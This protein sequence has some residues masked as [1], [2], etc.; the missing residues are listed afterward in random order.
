MSCGSG[1]SHGGR[2]RG[3]VAVVIGQRVTAQSMRGIGGQGVSAF[4][5]VGRRHAP[6]PA[7]KAF[8]PSLTS[9]YHVRPCP[10]RPSRALVLIPPGPSHPAPAQRPG[11]QVRTRPLFLLSP[12]DPAITRDPKAKAVCLFG[13]CGQATGSEWDPPAGM[14]GNWHLALGPPDLENPK[15]RKAVKGS[16]PPYHVLP[17]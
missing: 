13:W 4:P 16:S 5:A 7:A 3:W 2:G 11:Q 1:R 6:T 9:P 15:L 8:P 14:S 10:T 17:V 12:C